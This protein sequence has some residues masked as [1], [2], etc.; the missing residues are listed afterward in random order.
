MGTENCRI[1]REKAEELRDSLPEE[2]RALILLHDC[3]DPDAMAGGWCLKRLFNEIFQ[4][5]AVIV[6]GGIIG[7]PDNHA[8]VDLLEIPVRPIE[9]VDRA[10]EDYFICIDTQPSFTNHSLPSDGKVLGVIDHHQEEVE[11]EV[12]FVD[13]RHDCGA[14]T[15]ILAEYLRCLGGQ[16]DR[17]LAT[18]IAFAI[19]AES[20]DL[21]RPISQ[22]DLDLYVDML[23]VVD[24]LMLGQL[25][26][27]PVQRPF[28]R[29][30][31]AGLK[32]ARL[33][34]QLVVCHLSELNSSDELARVADA[35]N[36]LQDG[37]W[38]F[39]TG[40]YDG[41]L[42]LC[43]RTSDVTANA[44]RI[45]D[46][47]VREEGGAGGHGMV[48]GGRID[49]AG[50]GGGSEMREKLVGRLLGALGYDADQSREPL[51]VPPAEDMIPP[52]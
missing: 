49:L 13:V 44:G 27:P 11:Y 51:L 9:E 37:R 17:D 35:L 38:V 26:H 43:L 22:S 50:A 28:F 14:V 41:A 18:A 32:S 8:M 24:H 47:I 5:E 16:I 36:A 20:E 34:G 40:E 48:A 6:Y 33:Y 15:T 29:T 10:A 52:G 39:C 21:R 12:P 42:H 31:V 23:P 19:L 3:P 30:L 4:R 7:R 25:R 45:L 2:G 46:S 1:A